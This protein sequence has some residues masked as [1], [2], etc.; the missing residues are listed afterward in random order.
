M[1]NTVTL[2]LAAGVARAVVVRTAKTVLYVAVSLAL[3]SMSGAY[4]AGA[5]QQSGII[6]LIEGEG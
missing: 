2:Q 1:L 5:L 6:S 4:L 3:G